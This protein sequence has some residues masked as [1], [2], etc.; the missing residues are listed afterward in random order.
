MEVAGAR[1]QTGAAAAAYATAMA[2]L[3]LSPT[4]GLRRNLWQ[5]WILHPLSHS[6]NSHVVFR[7]AE[8]LV[9]A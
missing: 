4:F 9:G 1:D 8:Y 3:D 5:Y 7:C 2:T 6:R